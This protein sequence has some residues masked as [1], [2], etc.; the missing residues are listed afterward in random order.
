MAVTP[1]QALK[2]VHQLRKELTVAQSRTTELEHELADA[3]RTIAEMSKE[4]IA[5]SEWP[6]DP[7]EPQTPVPPEASAPPNEPA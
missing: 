6:D 1:T 2:Q 4:L 3:N 7:Q 5:R